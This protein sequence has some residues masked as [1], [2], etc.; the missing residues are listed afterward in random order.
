MKNMPR[1]EISIIIGYSN[2]SILES[3]IKTLDELRTKKLETSIKV[4]KKLEK[5]SLMKLSKNIFSVSFELLNIITIVIKI[6]IDDK[7]KIKLKLFW[8]KTPNIK[9]IKIENTKKI[10][11]N[12]IFK[13]LIIFYQSEVIY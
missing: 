6:I 11:G 13:L 7:L 9:V 3:K 12:K 2:L 8:I 1:I 4:L 5:L 10:S